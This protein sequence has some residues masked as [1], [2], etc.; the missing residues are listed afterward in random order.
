VE[1]WVPRRD[2]QR[3]EHTCFLYSP[4]FLPLGWCR[5]GGAL[6]CQAPPHLNLLDRARFDL[7]GGGQGIQRQARHVFL[8]VRNQEERTR[9]PKRPN[10][11]RAPSPRGTQ[12]VLVSSC[13]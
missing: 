13:W 11:P 12:N 5:V 9:S 10:A 8:E 3:W 4:Y 2:D 1:A 7:G 6:C